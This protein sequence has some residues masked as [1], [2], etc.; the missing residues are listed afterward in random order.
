MITYY[1]A[2]VTAMAYIPAKIP[3]SQNGSPAKPMGNPGEW[4]TQNDYPSKAL[5][6]ERQGTTAFRLFI[7]AKGKVTE[8]VVIDTSGSD[9]LDTTTCMLVKERA[10]FRP[11]TDKKGKAI[12][13]T[14][15]SRV[16][17]QI[18]DSV[19][20][21][22]GQRTPENGNI[23]VAFTINSDGSTS[24]CKVNEEPARP[25]PV[26]IQTICDQKATFVPYTNSQGKVVPVRVDYNSST[27]VTELSEK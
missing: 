13:G 6:Q 9:D 11:A 16:R 22:T 17:W 26:L 15:S 2:A 27:K 24:D 5:Q 23:T 1:L 14:Y 21:M 18:P 7:D 8:C 19:Q 20:G 4:V 3:A 12:A 10:S 25:S